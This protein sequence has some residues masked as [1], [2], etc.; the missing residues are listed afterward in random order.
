MEI[1]EIMM[2]NFG[3]FN[4]QSMSFHPGINIIYGGNETG[5]TT[6][7][8]FVKGMFFGIDK[9]RGR[10]ANKDEYSLRQPWENGSFFSGTIR[11]K[12]GGKIFRLDRNFDRNQ[13]SASLVCETDGE[14]LDTERGDLENLLE[15]MDETAFENTV[16]I[17]G[18]SGETTQALGDCVRNYMINTNNT[19]SGQIDVSAALEEL[20]EERKKLEREKKEKMAEK[21]ERL[22]EISM[23]M[24][25]THQEIDE[26]IREEQK[27][28]ELLEQFPA[29]MPDAGPDQFYEEFDSAE[30]LTYG[31]G[32]WKAGKIAMAVLAFVGVC[33]GL[34][35]TVWEARAAAA[36]IILAA[37]FGVRFFSE[38][39]MQRKEYL[40]EM[41][42]AHREKAVRAEYERQRRR[43]QQQR[44]ELPKRQRILMNIEWAVSARKEKNRYLEQLQREYKREQEGKED[45]RD[46]EEKISAIYLAIDTL[47]EVS[48]EMYS[49]YARRL[50]G[51]ISEILSFITDGKYTGVSLDEEFQIRIH[52]SRKVL[53]IWQVSRGTM[54]QIYF[55][56]RMAC[57]DL[58]D[59]GN[60]MPLILDD[61]FLT[62]DDTRLERTLKWLHTSGHQV[63]LFTC[64]KR[65][66]EIMQKIYG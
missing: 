55:A 9:M 45:I 52:T 25:Y 10:G 57:L 42:M 16:F 65:E 21:I 20:K 38:R 3:K 44:D 54:E 28:R 62:Y 8:A 43:L 40:R 61:A 19:A 37:C 48:G 7:G 63:L 29:D 6:M 24:E 60:S 58:I 41:K 33:M 15:G 17:S 22:Q 35:M 23:K 13:K 34:L 2:N 12:S 31:S 64:H 49:E 36:A 39:D 47:K 11:F 32:I 4:N 27:Y 5:K 66:Q 51:S 26:M 50:N 56:I 1:L 46:L 18:H 30:E 53:S 14:E 59:A